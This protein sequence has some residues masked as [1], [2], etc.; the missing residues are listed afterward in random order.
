MKMSKN[1]LILVKQIVNRWG[2]YS[3]FSKGASYENEEG[4]YVLVTNRVSYQC[5]QDLFLHGFVVTCNFCDRYSC[6]I[7]VKI[8]SR[9]SI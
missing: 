8:Y 5:L 9:R 6:S 3:E 7:E 1:D 4:A 2:E